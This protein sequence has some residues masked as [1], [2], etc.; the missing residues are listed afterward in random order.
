[1]QANPMRY[2]LI[3]EPAGVQQARLR[4]A[5][6]LGADPAGLAL[7]PNA[8]TAVSTVLATFDFAAGDQIVVSDHGYG[9]IRLAVDRIARESGATVT[10]AS[11]STRAD[12]DEIC[13]AVE[14]ALTEFSRLLVIDQVTSSTARVL[15]VDR[16]IAVAH[17]RSVPVLVD[18]AHT[19]GQLGVDVAALGA[20]FWTGVLHKW[21]CAARGTAV[22]AVAEQWRSRLAPLVTSWNDADGFPKAFDLAGTRDLTAWL[23]L[24]DALDL[25]DELSWDRLRIHGSALADFG[26]ATVAD[27]LGV[28]SDAL[29]REPD[30]WMRCVPLPEGVATT[31]DAARALWNVISDRL[32]CEVGVT[33]WTGRGLLRLSAH[34]YN[35][36]GEYERLAIGLRDLLG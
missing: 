17:D 8:T 11:F 6:F 30:L 2:S 3:E 5:A 14:A 31:T 34:A 7:V 16:I 33:T 1:M 36:P 27:A 29:W 22:L 20:D 26:Q 12:E 28:G 9:A 4:A 24:G 32:G 21:P 25:M 15:P 35:A 18:A 10:E 19:P 23:V 13:A